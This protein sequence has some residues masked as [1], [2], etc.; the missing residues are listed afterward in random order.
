MEVFQHRGLKYG[1]DVGGGVAGGGA[2]GVTACSEGCEEGCE[3][4]F[5][6]VGVDVLVEGCC[7]SFKEEAMR[8]VLVLL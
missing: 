7:E 5:A 1:E 6:C 2:I 3:V 8:V 4:V